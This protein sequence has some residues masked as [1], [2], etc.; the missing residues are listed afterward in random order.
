MHMH[1]H[2]FAGLG[3]CVAVDELA[4]LHLTIAEDWQKL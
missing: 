3:N 4:S 2:M 1:V